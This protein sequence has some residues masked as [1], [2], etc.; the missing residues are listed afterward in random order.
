MHFCFGIFLKIKK[1]FEIHWNM[2]I[3]RDNLL[4]TFNIS[5][6]RAPENSHRPIPRTVFESDE[7][8]TQW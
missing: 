5:S 7:T 6:L 4:I 8:F 3:F 1:Y 2:A